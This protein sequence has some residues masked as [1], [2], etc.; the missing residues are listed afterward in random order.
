M[1][2]S[3]RV[4]TINRYER[5]GI[6]GDLRKYVRDA[7][8]LKNKTEMSEDQ[9][10]SLCKEIW[11]R[12]KAALSASLSPS[13]LSLPMSE[14]AQRRENR[15]RR[16]EDL[17]FVA[18][19]KSPGHV[20]T[21]PHSSDFDDSDSDNSDF[22]DLEEKLKARA[23]S[24]N[25]NLS[26]ASTG[27]S[28]A[29]SSTSAGGQKNVDDEKALRELTS[30]LDTSLSSSDSTA[31][32]A[33]GGGAGGGVASETAAAAAA[34]H[35]VK[36]TGIN[37][38]F[39][40]P[41]KGAEDSMMS[42]SDPKKVSFA[43]D[44]PARVVKRITRVIDKTGKESIRVEFIFSEQ[45]VHRVEALNRRLRR[46]RQIKRLN[47]PFLLTQQAAL[48]EGN[49]QSLGGGGLKKRLKDD[50]GDDDDNNSDS[51][52]QF[53][54]PTMTINL[55]KLKSSAN[56]YKQSEGFSRMFGDDVDEEQM[57][58]MK[59]SSSRSVSVASQINYR[60]PRIS[61]AARLEKEVLELWNLKGAK[62]FWFPVDRGLYP[63]YYTLI[64]HPIS[65]MDIR[66]KVVKYCYETAAALVADVELMASNAEKFNGKDHFVTSLGWKLVSHL[67][68]SLDH[69][70]KHFGAEKD[71]IALME[72]AIRKKKAQL[73]VT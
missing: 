24:S 33:G 46:E 70:R 6:A 44:A 17:T 16:R 54:S 11:Q 42:P 47:S 58:L 41:V 28:G 40:D 51:E 7:T 29:T 60:T 25:R 32:G 13:M 36:V 52:Q 37:D 5:A 39:N 35:R 72:N 10:K 45:E 61:F 27:Q 30:V 67:K 73:Q 26:S 1:L 62:V 64:E 19:D 43:W 50:E 55:A 48:K 65:L 59:S 34:K 12:Q 56:Q 69:D 63:S 3:S 68:E 23:E 57:F 15:R 31:A 71:V 66:E 22:A 21:S 2:L 53:V 14:D 49:A 20:S 4:D 8:L 18:G 38:A 9:Y